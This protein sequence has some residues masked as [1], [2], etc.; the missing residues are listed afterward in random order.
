MDYLSPLIDFFGDEVDS[1]R[2]FDPVSQRSLGLLDVC[3]L[4]PAYEVLPTPTAEGRDALAAL[5]LS[6]MP[7]DL[8]S[9]YARERTWCARYCERPS[10][11]SATGTRLTRAKVVSRLGRRPRDVGER[12]KASFSSARRGEPG[13]PF[14]GT[15]R[16]E[17]PQVLPP[18]GRDEAAGASPNTPRGLLGRLTDSGR[19]PKLALRRS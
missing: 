19:S 2:R 11:S 12:R 3:V 1:L 13:S 4:A 15:G 17:R 18:P 7:D 9:A 5:D 10:P 16:E 6:D 14:G 8:A